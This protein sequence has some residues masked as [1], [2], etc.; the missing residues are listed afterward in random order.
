LKSVQDSSDIEAIKSAIAELSLE[1]QKIGQQ[2][3]NKGDEG[4]QGTA[5]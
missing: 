1:L 2:M 4:Q 3:Y 5:Q